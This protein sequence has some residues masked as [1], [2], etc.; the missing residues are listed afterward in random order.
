M[1]RIL[2]NLGALACVRGEYEQAEQFLQ[3]GLQLARQMLLP[4]LLCR[5]LYQWGGLSLQREQLEVAAAAFE[6]MLTTAPEGA[7]LEPAL[8]QYGLARVAAALGKRMEARQRGE[9][10][11]AM[12]TATGHREAIQV[13]HWLENLA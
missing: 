10:A 4:P 11:L 12:L 5:A 9:E 8:A 3:E 1:A 13:R 2:T 7:R 6:E